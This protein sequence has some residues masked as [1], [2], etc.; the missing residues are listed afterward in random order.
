MRAALIVNRSEPDPGFVGEAL[1]R[2]GYGLVPLAR[3]DH[4]DWPSPHG[5]DLVV[6]LGS[7]W[8]TYWPDVADPVRAEQQFLAGAIGAG[9]GV[10]GI[11]FGAQQLS[12]VLG[13]VVTK[14][15]SHEI[16]WFSV[17]MTQESTEF[18]PFALAEGPWMQWHYDR[19]TVPEGAVCLATSPVGPQAFLAGRALGLQFH[20]EATEAIVGGWSSGTGGDEL[21][22]AGIDRDLLMGRTRTESVGSRRRCNDIVDWFVRDVAQGHI[23]KP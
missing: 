14:A 20:P 5:F 6:A 22:E 11:C 21:R 12:T 7:A 23:R 15:Q 8:S 10:L 1:G 13:G 19:F 3:E 17:E 16:G 18:A 9:I 4:A 2:H